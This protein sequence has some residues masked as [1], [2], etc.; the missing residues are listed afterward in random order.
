[1]NKK[2]IYLILCISLFTFLLVGCSDEIK[3]DENNDKQLKKS[4]EIKPLNKAE[5]TKLALERD[6][7]ILSSEQRIEISLPFSA[8]D[9][10]IGFMPLGETLYHPPPG[11]PG[12]DFGWDHNAI[13]RS[14][15]DGTVINISKV[16]EDQEGNWVLKIKSG[17]YIFSYNYLEDI[18]VIVGQD[19]KKG[20]P[21]GHPGMKDSNNFVIHWDIGPNVGTEIIIQ[22]K[23]CP[24]TYFDAESRK[25]LE[26]VHAISKWEHKEKFPKICNGY[27]D[28][29]DSFLGLYNRSFNSNGDLIKPNG[30]LVMKN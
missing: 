1:M 14:S 15:S 11:H 9:E 2:H 23:L 13:V 20:E 4:E 18:S 30:E 3:D 19:V 8:E 24:L 16:N 29:L 27:Y 21:L 10:I 25:R 6:M 17:Q 22:E 28:G 26:A 7:Q 12:F 5:E